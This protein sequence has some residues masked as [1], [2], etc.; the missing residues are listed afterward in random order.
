MDRDG[1]INELAGFVKSPADFNLIDGAAEA[2]RMLNASGYLAIVATNQPVVARGECSLEALDEI[3]K[4]METELGRR[5][6][7]LDGIYF[8]PHHPHGGYEGEVA[9]LKVD[10]ACRKPKPGMLLKAAEDLNI[11]LSQSWMVGDSTTDIQAGISA[12]ARTVLVMTGE[13]G[14]DGKGCAAPDY[15]APTLLD[16][17]KLILSKSQKDCSMEFKDDIREYIALE[18]ET[19]KKLDADAINEALNLL[20][21]TARRRKRVYV[22]GNGG[23]SATASHFQNDFAKGASQRAADKFRFCCLNDNVPTLTAIANDIGFEEVF[24]FQLEGVIEPGDVVIAI[25]GSGNSRN[26]LNA[27]EYAKVCGNKVIGLT[28]YDGGKLKGLSDISLH[29]PVHSMQV[30]EDIHMVLDHLMMSA[31]C[32]RQQSKAYSNGGGV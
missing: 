27:V 5:G 1:T 4:K 12:G 22:F 31:L 15:T 10:C 7:F 26:V 11:D 18:I 16:A 24:R 2:I 29:V 25:S 9:E 30:A 23:S 21:E 3:H 20:V 6:A 28:G 17:V 14:Q 19:L 13:A 8:C 32:K